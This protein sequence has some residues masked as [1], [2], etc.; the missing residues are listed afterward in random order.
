MDNI[1]KKMHIVLQQLYRQTKAYH[2]KC[3]LGCKDG[4]CLEGKKITKHI[5]VCQSLLNIVQTAKK[6][7]NKKIYGLG[8]RARKVRN[9][10]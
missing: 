10:Q 9:S 8:C 4:D 5:Q 7:N 3:M 1:I 6:E 2:R